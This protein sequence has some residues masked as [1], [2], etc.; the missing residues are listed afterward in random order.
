MFDIL[1]QDEVEALLGAVSQG[2]FEEPPRLIYDT[3]VVIDG[4]VF[5]WD[6]DCQKV[7]KVNLTPVSNFKVTDD[8]IKAVVMQKFGLC[9][10]KESVK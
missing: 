9:V 7:V 4:D 8:V 2:D 5:C 6:N 3:P 1:T 10:P